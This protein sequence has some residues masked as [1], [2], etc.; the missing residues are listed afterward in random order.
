VDRCPGSRRSC[1]ACRGRSGRP[2]CSR[3]VSATKQLPE[4]IPGLWNA[5]T[6]DERNSQSPVSPVGVT[7]IGG[8]YFATGDY[9]SMLG[10]IAR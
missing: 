1:R 6:G 7:R 10:A 2:I 9:P 4:T 8:E 5:I 3:A